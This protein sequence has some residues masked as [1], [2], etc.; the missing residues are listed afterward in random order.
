MLQDENGVGSWAIEG[1]V[2][3]VNQTNRLRVIK[4]ISCESSNGNGSACEGE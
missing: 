2:G 1:S 3:Q 4:G